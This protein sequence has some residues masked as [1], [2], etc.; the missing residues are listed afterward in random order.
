MNPVP[1]L[2]GLPGVDTP[3]P[4]ASASVRMAAGDYTTTSTSFTAVDATNL[5]LSITLFAVHRVSITLVGTCANSTLGD[6]VRFDVAVDGTRLGGVN[7]ITGLKEAVAGDEYPLSINYLT[8]P[9]SAGTHTFQLQWFASAAT[10]T[11]SANSAGTP[12]RF[13]VVEQPC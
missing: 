12:L 9:L 4:L 6:T 13:A 5:T 10:A 1:G 3:I 2:P 8:D 11:L 7:G